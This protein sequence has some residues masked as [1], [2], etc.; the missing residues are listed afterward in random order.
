MTDWDISTLPAAIAGLRDR[1]HEQRP[2]PQRL[3][4]HEVQPRDLLGSP[5]LSPQFMGYI[6]GGSYA[7]HWVEMTSMCRD[8][9]PECFLCHGQGW[10]TYSRRAWDY[11]LGMALQKLAHDRSPIGPTWPSRAVMVILLGWS[12]FDVTTAAYRVGHP[13][14]SPDHRLTVEA[15]FLASIRDLARLY[16]PWAPDRKRIEKSD[17]QINAEDAA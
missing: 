1:W 4:V 15:Q 3:H 11:P 12:E 17:A 5:K 13:I 10:Y 14:T 6:S 2:T 7:W 16:S 8:E 9:D